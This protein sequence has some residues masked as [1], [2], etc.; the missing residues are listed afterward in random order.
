M[1]SLFIAGLTIFMTLVDSRL[2]AAGQAVQLLQEVAVSANQADTID[3]ALQTA[4]NQVCSFTGWPL[5]HAYL[6]DVSFQP[7]LVMAEE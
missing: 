5:G 2:E 1:A 6:R 4:I 7:D 3:I